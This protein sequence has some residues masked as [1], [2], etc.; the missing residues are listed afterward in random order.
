VGVV[1]TA[2]PAVITPAT[3]RSPR[4]P[5]ELGFGLLMLLFAAFLIVPM[6]G[7]VLFSISE[8]WV[9]TVIPTR[10]TP[11]YWI[12]ALRDP[13]F[14][15]TVTRSV[16]ASLA[17]MVV[18]IVLMAPTLYILHIGA[19]RLRPAVEII[20]LAPFALPAVV[21]ALG[22]IRAYSVPPLVLTGTPTILIISYTVIS[23]PFVYRSIDNAMLSVD[24]RT[25]YEAARTLGA[26]RWA[27]FRHIVLPGIRRGLAAAALLVFAATFGEY[28]L[29]A[30]LVGDLWQTSGVWLYKMWDQHP[31]ET[32]AIGIVS[33]AVSWG[34]SFALLYLFGR[35]GAHERPG[36]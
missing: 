7:T 13:L 8:G 20:S 3:A 32:M 30:F 34:C 16:I 24:T 27:P 23:L 29:S 28:T 35:R 11:E 9:D 25:L 2:D 21:F 31:H 22:L 18:S 10:Y 14:L 1:T 36:N 15:P 5:R 33:F 26:S 12:N 6:V 17:T 4:R 19:R